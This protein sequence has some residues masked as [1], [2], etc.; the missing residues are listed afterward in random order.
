M[1]S[2]NLS[3]TAILNIKVADYCCLTSGINKSEAINLMQN[4]DLTEK[5]EHY[6]TYI[7]LSNIKMGQEIITFGGLEIEKDDFYCDKSD[8]FWRCRYWESIII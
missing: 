4:I 7:F 6:K 3:D 1:M 2:M 5:V 8:V